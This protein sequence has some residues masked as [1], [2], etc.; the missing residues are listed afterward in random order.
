MHSER[1]AIP[2]PEVQDLVRALYVDPEALCERLES[3]DSGMAVTHG[4]YA[5]QSHASV[6]DLDWNHMDPHHRYYV[7]GTY[8]QALRLCTGPDYQ[9]SITKYGSWPI[10]VVM[11]DIRLAP[12]LFYQCFSFFNIV[13]I[14]SV[15]R[16]VEHEGGTQQRVDWYIASKRLW[17]FL[18]PWLS[19]KMER[20][21]RLQNAEDDPIR[22][23]RFQL[24]NRGYCF[25]SDRPDFVVASSLTHN[26]VPPKLEHEH[27]IQLDTIHSEV[28][29]AFSVEHLE[30]LYLT[31]DAAGVRLWPA[32]CPHEGGPLVNSLVAPESGRLKCPWHGLE[33]KAVHLTPKGPLGTCLG[34]R[35][36]LEDGRLVIS[37]A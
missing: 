29:K 3:L 1:L 8:G 19:R 15:I 30:F 35:F 6:R 36:R 22:L 34:A 23:R 33:T 26:V 7:H 27:V 9:I 12:G 2:I 11:S 13:T 31:D 5:C 32:V 14:V 28:L 17:K 18:H 21:N 16:S 24:R 37:P 20:L 4:Y 10:F 25:H